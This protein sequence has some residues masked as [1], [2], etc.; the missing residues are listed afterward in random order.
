VEAQDGIFI[1]RKRS[2]DHNGSRYYTYMNID[3][4][5]EKVGLEGKEHNLVVSLIFSITK[6][7]R[8]SYSQGIMG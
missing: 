8:G 7:L 4:R 6:F 2:M 5:V 1:G 3:K